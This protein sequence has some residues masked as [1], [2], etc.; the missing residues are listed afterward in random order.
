MSGYN[1]YR[2]GSS[3]GLFTKQNASLL[4]VTEYYDDDYSLTGA[5]YYKVTAVNS[6]GL[7]SSYSSVVSEEFD[8]DSN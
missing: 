5:Y 2:S 7:E 8:W 3:S 1:I 4:S 6:S